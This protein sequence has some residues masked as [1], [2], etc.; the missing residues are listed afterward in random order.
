MCAGPWF[1]SCERWATT[2]VADTN[3]LLYRASLRAH[4]YLG[5]NKQAIRPKYRCF[6]RLSWGLETLHTSEH[7]TLC[8]AK[9]L[10][11]ASPLS[12]LVFVS[13]VYKLGPG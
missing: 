12:Y 3:V 1:R 13:L 7:I 8:P 10:N 11:L 9:Y 5:I 4:S 2:P 6:G